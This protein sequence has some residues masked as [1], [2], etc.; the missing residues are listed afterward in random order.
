MDVEQNLV[1]V[2][3]KISKDEDEE[4]NLGESGENCIINTIALWIYVKC[5][6]SKNLQIVH[7]DNPPIS[8]D[9]RMSAFDELHDLLRTRLHES[10]SHPTQKTDLWRCFLKNNT[11]FYASLD[12]PTCNNKTNIV[13][14]YS[15]MTSTQ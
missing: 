10:R 15:C 9:V 12:H 2:S 5:L 11:H 3:I 13:I 7:N 1:L 8:N 6:S 4:N 14:R